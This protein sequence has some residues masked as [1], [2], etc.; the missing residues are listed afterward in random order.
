[1]LETKGV[2]EVRGACVGT[3]PRPPTVTLA[4]VEIKGVV[5]VQVA[6]MAGTAAGNTGGIGA[7]IASADARTMMALAIFARVSV[8]MPGK[9]LFW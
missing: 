6:C 2:V 3:A 1:M 8:A 9:Q 5:E 7:A 4:G